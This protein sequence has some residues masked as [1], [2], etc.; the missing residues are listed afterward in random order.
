[1]TDLQDPAPDTLPTY[2]TEKLPDDITAKSLSAMA[3]Q[4]YGEA[5]PAAALEEMNKK[6]LPL[7]ALEGDR[8]DLLLRQAQTLD[9]VFHFMLQNGIAGPVDLP[10]VALALRAQQQSAEIINNVAMRDYYKA[11]SD[12]MRRNTTRQHLMNRAKRQGHDTDLL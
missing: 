10:S 9:M 1:M 11:L 4:L 2:R 7:L 8:E 6:L 12:K 3:A 5:H